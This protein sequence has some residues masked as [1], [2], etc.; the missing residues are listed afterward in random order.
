MKKEEN[1][2]TTRRAGLRQLWPMQRPF[3]ILMRRRLRRPKRPEWVTAGFG[4]EVGWKDAIKS[5]GQGMQEV[6]SSVY[7]VEWSGVEWWGME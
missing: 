5:V 4:K 7:E 2:S 1:P 6:A 3:S